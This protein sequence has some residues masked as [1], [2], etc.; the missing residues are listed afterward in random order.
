[1]KGKTIIQIVLGVVIVA[2]AF[3]LYNSI[4]KPVRFDNE[5]TK[6]RDA[7]AEKLKAIRTLEEAHKQAYGTYCGNYDTLL[8]NLHKQE[9]RVMKKEKAENAVKKAK[10]RIRELDEELNRF[11]RGQQKHTPTNHKS[12]KNQRNLHFKKN[13]K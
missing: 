6:R 10:A 7:C 4:M 2:L 11:I 5:Y 1:M 3:L 13:K 12:N 8:I 9:Q